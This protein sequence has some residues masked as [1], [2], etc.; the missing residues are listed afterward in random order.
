MV[1]VLVSK[2]AKFV[3]VTSLLL[4]GAAGTL[5]WPQGWVFLVETAGLSFASGLLLL[6]RDPAL[7]AVR[8]GS[9]K[10]EGQPLW[11][12]VFLILL[13]G[14][15]TLWLVV[16]AFDAIRF[17]WSA[18]PVWL[19]VV[20]ALIYPASLAGSVRVVLENSFAA[21][22]V[23]LQRE[24]GQRVIDSGPYALVRHP[25]YAITLPGLAAVPLLLGS[26]YGLIA[27]PLFIAML[28]ARTAAE[29]RLLQRELN[30]YVDYARRVPWRLVP[31]LW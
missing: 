27:V 26:W 25:M 23:R 4:F 28:V 31:G 24:R 20:G 8:M 7:L 11:D 30:G 9:F 19:N 1:G 6:K 17:G 12:R 16:M 29:D 13:F 5:A 18:M 3:V 2:T 22:V 21:P 10:Q 14:G 15:F